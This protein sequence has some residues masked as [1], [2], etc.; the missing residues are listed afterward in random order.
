MGDQKKGIRYTEKYSKMSKVRPSFSAIILHLHGLNSLIK[1]Y[2]GRVDKMSNL[3]ISC[4]KESHF[5][6]RDT[7]K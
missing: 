3:N 2:I 1:K 5:R 7:N 6:Y 4:L